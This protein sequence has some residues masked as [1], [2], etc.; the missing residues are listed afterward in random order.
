[1]GDGERLRI[2][3]VLTRILRQVA[4]TAGPFD[5]AALGSVVTTQDTEERGLPCAISAN[6]SDLV[7]RPDLKGGAIND[8]LPPDFNNEVPDV[9]HR[10]S[11]PLLRA[12]A[13]IA[14]LWLR[15]RFRCG[16]RTNAVVRGR[17]RRG[18]LFGEVLRHGPRE[19]GR[20]RRGHWPRCRRHRIRS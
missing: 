12:G 14:V 3:G 18:L 11:Q 2:D 19:A 15:N 10:S 16:I 1:M 9:Q 5:K 20:L 13:D 6:E 8:G 17:P 7:A 4:S